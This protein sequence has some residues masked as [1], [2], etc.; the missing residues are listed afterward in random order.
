MSKMPKFG[1]ALHLYHKRYSGAHYQGFFVREIPTSLITM[2]CPDI[3][4]RSSLEGMEAKFAALEKQLN[5]LQSVVAAQQYATSPLYR[6]CA[7][8]EIPK[9]SELDT[10]LLVRREKPIES[11]C[12]IGPTNSLYSLDVGKSSLRTMGVQPET[13]QVVEEP[14]SVINKARTSSHSQ[15]RSETLLYDTLLCMGKD[16]ALRLVSVYAEELDPI[17][18]FLDLAKVFNHL[19]LLLDRLKVPLSVSRARPDPKIPGFDI[20]DSEILMLVL[21][22]ALI[23]EGLGQ[24]EVAEYMVDAVEI[25][26]NRRA[27]TRPADL[28]E[29]LILTIMVRSDSY[30]PNVSVDC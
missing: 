6:A 24:S 16:E 25:S 8:S 12:F 17:Y 13:E 20:R 27:K 19:E 30:L 1:L 15:P 29:V 21:A 22:S 4:Y 2:K 3:T 28:K 11:P 7:S 9:E 26:R 23:I 10:E 5:Q 18:P 14:P